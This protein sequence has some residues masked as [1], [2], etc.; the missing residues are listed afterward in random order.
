M[1]VVASAGKAGQGDPDLEMARGADVRYLAMAAAR[2]RAGQVVNDPARSDLLVTARQDTGMQWGKAAAV[3]VL[4]VGDV[5]AVT[6]V[7]EPWEG[8]DLGRRDV[9]LLE[10]VATQASIGVQRAQLFEQVR[11]ALSEVQATHRRYLRRAWDAYLQGRGSERQAYILGPDGV[12]TVP[13]L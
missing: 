7:S 4:V 11:S 6:V 12:Q 3:P 8:A 5:V 1:E 2:K 13:D 10:A 9:G